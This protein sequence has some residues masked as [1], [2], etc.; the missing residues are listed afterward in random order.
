MKKKKN[1]IKPKVFVETI[2]PNICSR[3]CGTILNN[4]VGTE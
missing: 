1:L 3:L 4:S 2:I